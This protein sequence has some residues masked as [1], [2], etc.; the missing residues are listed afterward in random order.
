MDAQDFSGQKLGQY[1]LQERLGAGG[2]GAVYR[3]L[4]PGLNRTVAVKVLSGS[5]VLRPGYLE[6]FT[7]EA[8]TAAA[9][10]HSHIVPVYDYGT[11]GDVSYIVMRLLP[12]GSLS[13][14][15]DKL[16][17]QG[18][19]MSLPEI[20]K[21]LTQLGEA[22]DYAH[23][24]GVIHR[25][26]KPGN[27]MFDQAGAAFI[28]DFGIAKLV[29]GAQLT[30]TGMT[31][32]TPAYMP[33]EQ[34]R[35][36]MI[37]SASDQYAL[38]AV[39]YNMVAGRLPFEAPTPYALMLKHVS[40][41]LPA[42][43]NFRPDVPEAVSGVLAR[44]MAKSADD[45]YP[46]VG[47]FAQAFAQAIHAAPAP[48]IRDSTAA[49]P[50]KPVGSNAPIQTPPPATKS[51]SPLPF[52]AGIGAVAALILVGFVLTRPPGASPA[53]TATRT[54]LP[55]AALSTTAAPPTIA[56]TTA[57][58]PTTV[59][60]SVSQPDNSPTPLPPTPLPPT[61]APT[62]PPTPIPATVITTRVPPTATNPPSPTTSTGAAAPTQ[63][64]SVNAEPTSVAV[65]PPQSGN[66]DVANRIV[67]SSGR[68]TRNVIVAVKADGSGQRQ[69]LDDTFVQVGV[70]VSP[71]GKQIAYISK[72]S[73]KFGLYIANSDGSS[74]RL[75]REGEPDSFWI[76]PQW[77]GDQIMYEEY[78]SV[79]FYNVKTGNTERR[80][81]DGLGSVVWGLDDKTLYYAAY[82]SALSLGQIFRLD[83]AT[84]KVTK[85]SDGTS[86]DEQ[87]ALSPDGKQIVF[88]TKSEKRIG[89]YVMDADG[90]NPRKLEGARDY[91][92]APAWS[93]D[94]K[95]IAFVG[96]GDTG[97]QIV[98]VMDA[99]G[100]NPRAL[101][102]PTPGTIGMLSWTL[103]GKEII[104]RAGDN[105]G[106]IYIMDA[107]GKNP[108]RLTNTPGYDYAP[109]L[110]PDGKRVVFSADGNLTVMNS[111]G[112]GL[113]ALE[114]IYGIEP[115]WSPDGKLI[116][117]SGLNENSD[118]PLTIINADGTGKKVLDVAN[119]ANNYWP[120]FSPD[121]RQIVFFSNRNGDGKIFV[122]NVDGSGLRQLTPDGSDDVYPAWSPDGRQIVF[123]NRSDN[124]GGLFTMNA[125]GTD[126]K[127]LYKS[128]RSL[129]QISWGAT[130]V[131]IFSD[132][133][134]GNSELYRLTL[135]D[136]TVTRLTDS[137]ASDTHG[138][139]GR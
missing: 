52:V 11:Q 27:I 99:D 102:T 35:A 13:D 69:L 135:A 131:I 129:E 70:T 91:D 19:F 127:L 67:F 94:S 139:F 33:P 92:T 75:V 68:D 82:D 37:T 130:G 8:Q 104:F 87:P 106:E 96:Y 34:W 59:V 41:T 132:E 126:R 32:G 74:P 43:N 62:I 17:E 9:L 66:I 31:V 57:A 101:S 134:T 122:I 119:G 38:G 133:V 30:T 71:D 23:A 93:P 114:G 105:G 14:R 40:E 83:L 118:R 55:I 29:D 111:D 138:R 73:G 3:A 25:D 2:M 15:L 7:R 120:S 12:G 108:R 84:S 20:A 58:P 97:G 72:I 81:I 109:A 18:K 61:V 112:S 4:Q 1:E 95:R 5:L 6:R 76:R 56:P 121:G 125:D 26:I 88:Y 117:Y 49:L 36:E 54:A 77:K 80:R 86:N 63:D 113:V 10:E 89:I 136:G 123:M 137:P 90:K 60:A 115:A 48:S 45:R 124:P 22:L 42:A 53:A 85:I 64:D 39:I 78:D 44:A 107:D 46:S 98:N 100:K 28:V 24:R 65:L 16:T 103:D 47:A 128:S 116:A 50:V 110:S 21:I 51:R 79:Y